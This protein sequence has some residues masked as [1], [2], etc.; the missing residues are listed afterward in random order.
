MQLVTA[1]QLLAQALLLRALEGLH[2]QLVFARQLQHHIAEAL[3]LQLHQEL[4][5]IAAGPAGEAV[6]ELLG[7]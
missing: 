4:D 5:G 1:G 3:T 7:R 2:R 6:V